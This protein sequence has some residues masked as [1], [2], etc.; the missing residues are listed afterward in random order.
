M[1]TFFKTVSKQ[2]CHRILGGS[3]LAKLP[4]PKNLP[5]KATKNV[6][7]K[8]QHAGKEERAYSNAAL[9]A[10]FGCAV[11]GLAAK[12][13][14]DKLAEASKGIDGQELSRLEKGMLTSV[15]ATNGIGG[16]ALL[17]FGLPSSN[18]RYRLR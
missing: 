5:S 16:A 11:T 14:A 4:L 13:I 6:Y 18:L 7:E 3:T 9:G 1:L 2:P 12:P 10:I 17:A 8:H 15:I